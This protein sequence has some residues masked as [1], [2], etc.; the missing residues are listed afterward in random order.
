MNDTQT[1]LGSLGVYFRDYDSMVAVGTDLY[2][3]CYGV[4]KYDTINN[5]ISSVPSPYNSNL[6]GTRMASVG[7]AIYFFGNSEN[8]SYANKAYRYDT[9]ANTYTQLTDI[10]FNFSSNRFSCSCWK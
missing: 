8:S 2:Y 3:C 5:T 9:L 10:P 1:S 4:G 7:T 6:F